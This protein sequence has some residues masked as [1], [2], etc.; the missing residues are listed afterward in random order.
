MKIF[1]VN[2]TE[3]TIRINSGEKYTLP[4]ST[5]QI[6]D[7][8]LYASTSLVL[9]ASLTSV[10]SIY[11][12]D[13]ASISFPDGH[14]ISAPVSIPSVQANKLLMEHCPNEAR[15][16]SKRQGRNFSNAYF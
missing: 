13:D 8:E 2:N 5:T 11:L 12:Y 9:P 7:I 1:D 14:V 3:S 6:G 10:K 15:I 4:E 16:E